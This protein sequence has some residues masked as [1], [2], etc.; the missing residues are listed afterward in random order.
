MARLANDL[1][2]EFGAERVGEVVKEARKRGSAV[3]S[4]WLVS[5]LRHGWEFAKRG[6]SYRQGCGAMPFVPPKRAEV[7]AE[8]APEPATVSAPRLDTAPD[9]LDA[10]SVDEYNALSKIAE[11]Q[12]RAQNPLFGRIGAPR[13]PRPAVR[14]RMRKLLQNKQMEQG[15]QRTIKELYHGVDTC[16]DLINPFE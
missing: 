8:T 2:T 16:D 13:L 3:G 14:D 10:L 1:V 12:I 5:A 9:A 11:E 15:E 7:A 4:G 6:D